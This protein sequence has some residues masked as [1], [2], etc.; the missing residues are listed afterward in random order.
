MKALARAVWE[1]HHATA[2]ADQGPQ[3]FFSEGCT[4]FDSPKKWI[5]RLPLPKNA[6]SFLTYS[7]L[8]KWTTFCYLLIESFFFFFLRKESLSFEHERK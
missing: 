3:D 7:G 8:R 6:R 4:S 1:R 5:R 2:A